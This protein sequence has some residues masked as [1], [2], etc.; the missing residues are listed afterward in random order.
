MAS[1]TYRGEYQW[2]VKIRRR[3]YPSQSKTFE[4]KSDAEKWA[5]MIES[6]MDRG[7]FRPLAESERTTL[8]ELLERY[9]KE[10]SPTKNGW[11]QE[12]SRLRVIGRYPLS[13][14][15][16][17]N[18]DGKALAEYRD[19]RLREVAKATVVSELSLIGNVFKVAIKDWGYVLPHGNPID[20]VRKPKIGNNRRD[21]RL[22]SG[23]EERLLA[24][25]EEYGGMI[26]SIIILA[27]ETGMRRGELAKLQWKCVCWLNR[28]QILVANQPPI[29]E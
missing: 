12:R 17:A 8:Q 22:Y 27:L 18:I 15:A 25:A 21:R 2:Q 10:V 23:E 3:G 9:S 26:R 4:S 16:I 6:E 7:V 1:I 11:E 13:E 19:T 29:M 20:A 14:F 5:R 24:A 28:P